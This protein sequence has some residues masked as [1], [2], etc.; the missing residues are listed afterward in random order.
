MFNH[1]MSGHLFSKDVM[2]ELTGLTGS[3]W[4]MCQ[5]PGYAGKGAGTHHQTVMK[6]RNYSLKSGWSSNR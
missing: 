5:L 2:S 6:K 4:Q 1:G 3:L